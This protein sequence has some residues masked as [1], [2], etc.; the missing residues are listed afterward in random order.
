[1]RAS[2][3]IRRRP[4]RE[5]LIQDIVATLAYILATLQISD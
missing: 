5:R 1:V 2:L 4:A 3:I